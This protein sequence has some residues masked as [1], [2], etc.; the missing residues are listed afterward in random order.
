MHSGKSGC[1]VESQILLPAFPTPTYNYVD[2]CSHA[3]HHITQQSPVNFHFVVNT[4]FTRPRLM[5]AAHT[6][7]PSWSTSYSLGSAQAG[8]YLICHTPLSTHFLAA[9]GA[10]SPDY[11]VST[12]LNL[13]S[14]R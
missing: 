6:K 4:L 7:A 5:R 13:P 9:G 2:P 1:G 8:L 3:P 11:G 14:G 12:E 10:N